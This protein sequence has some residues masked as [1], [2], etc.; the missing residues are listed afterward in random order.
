MKTMK[1]N[2]KEVTYKI[3]NPGGNQ[4]ALVLGNEYTK[5][6]IGNG[7]TECSSIKKRIE[8]LDII[9]IGANMVKIHSIDET[10]YIS[11]WLKTFNFLIKFLESLRF[12][13]LTNTGKRD[14]MN[15]KMIKT[16]TVVCIWNGGKDGK[17]LKVPGRT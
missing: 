4:T 9:S 10:T 7:G 14:S 8:D 15:C 5:E 1:I 2:Q 11:S 13:T 12:G 6:E 3:L 17:N 16:G